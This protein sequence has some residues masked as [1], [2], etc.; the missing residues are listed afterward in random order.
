M[1]SAEITYVG[2]NIFLSRLLSEATH[3]SIYL[4]ILNGKLP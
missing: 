1:K 3:A 2:S 4:F